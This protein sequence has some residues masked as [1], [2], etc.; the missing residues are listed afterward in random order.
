MCYIYHML[1]SIN[2]TNLKQNLLALGFNLGM[3]FLNKCTQL[4]ENSEI[5]IASTEIAGFQL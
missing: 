5:H 2:N 4:K 3:E 1:C